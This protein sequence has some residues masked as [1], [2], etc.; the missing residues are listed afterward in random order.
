MWRVAIIATTLLAI[1][2]IG[3]VLLLV[4][5]PPRITVSPTDGASEVDPETSYLEVSTSRWGASVTGVQVES[6]F[7]AP[8]GSR[9][10]EAMVS[11][12]LEQGRYLLK[13]GSNPLE[14]DTEYSVTVQGTVKKFSLSGISDEN[15][16]ETYTF[17]TITT[18]MPKLTG[19]GV[20]V[21]YNE[22]AL[23]EWNIPLEDVGYKLEGIG[24][25]T[26]IDPDDASRTYIA[27]ESFEQGMEYPL[28]ITTAT[29]ANGRVLQQ[30][31]NIKLVTAPALAVQMEPADGATGASLDTR[32]TLVFSEPVSNPELISSIVTVTPQVE[33]SFQWTEPNRLEFI[34]AQ[35]WDHLQDVTISLSGGPSLLRGVSGGF[36]GGDVMSTFTTAPYKMIEVDISEQ[37]LTL[38]E[39]GVV[40]D[41]FLCSTGL[42]STATPLGDYTIYAKLTKTDMRGEDYFAPDVPWVLVFKG[43]YTIH[44][45]YW[46][47]AF[48]RRSS[49]GC[50]GLPPDTA[51]Y[52]YDWTPVGTPVSI[53]E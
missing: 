37:T 10:N 22:E 14:H 9:I 25:A 11:G 5:F 28:T 53:H 40:V 49:H 32:P 44:G 50:V 23:I 26:R 19:E 27:L 43:D 33:G 18:P 4:V 34:P 35:S 29:S 39:N 48:G 24:S 1:L 52:L 47:T 16:T 46:A 17:T 45:N 6:A 30:P 7:I 15:V 2:V 42:S 13:N 31:V 8:D 41:N 3:I 21:R 36:V 20:F 12:N 51:K 38:Y